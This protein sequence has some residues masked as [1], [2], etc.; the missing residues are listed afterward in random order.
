MKY[1]II[2]TVTIIFT[3]FACKERDP[4]KARS[5]DDSKLNAIVNFGGTPAK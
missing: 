5:S 3:L 1:K 4:L 2:A